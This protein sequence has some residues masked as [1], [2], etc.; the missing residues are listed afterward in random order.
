[1][2]ERLKKNLSNLK[3]KLKGIVSEKREEI[4]EA[5]EHS[6]VTDAETY[7][8]EPLRTEEGG[9][10]TATAAE[11]EVVVE[12]HI[13]AAEKEAVEA[14]ERR[15]SAV[16]SGSATESEVTPE[17]EI[18]HTGSAGEAVTER[19]E[20]SHVV[21]REE[22]KRE[23]KREKKIGAR[24]RAIFR[25]E[26]V[27]DE[28]KLDGILEEFEEELLESDV[29]LPVAEKIISNVRQNLTGRKHGANE[30]VSAIVSNALKDALLSVFPDSF[31]IVYFIRTHEKPVKIVFVG[32]NGTGKTTT[33]AK[34]AHFLM[35]RGFSVVLASADTYRT[36]AVE[37]LEKHAAALGVRVIK[38]KY[39]AD[40]AAVVYDAIKYAE[41]HKKDVVLADTAGRM[42][43]NVNLMEQLR[44]ICRVTKPD[45]V[46]FVDEAIAGNDAV[47]RARRFNEYVGIDA[48]VLTK[49]DMDVKGGAAISIAYITSKPVLF[50]GTGQ[51][52]DDLMP[53]NPEEFVNN[54]IR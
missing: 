4:T 38:H 16:P 49:T 20:I 32:V 3:E 27:L 30:D 47:E 36:G 5:R 10:G 12:E 48:S 28:R 15:V 17:S 19:A 6:E 45:L 40:P 22:K 14:I 13:G 46:I 1:M 35:E 39:G 7:A 42:H 21:E 23:E 11:E 18:A 54:L 24:L 9:A 31:D 29:A 43:T 8:A 33:I 51:K 26:I 2:F 52:Y 34:F 44:K 41:A 53:F 25:R 37:Q 50:L